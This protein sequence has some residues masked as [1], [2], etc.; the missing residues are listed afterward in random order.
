MEPGSPASLHPR[1]LAL[2]ISAAMFMGLLNSMVIGPAMPHMALSFHVQPVELSIGVTIYVLALTVLLPT[3]A[4]IADRF[5]PRR[6]FITAIAA[7]TVTSACVGLTQSL[8]QFV[9]ARGLQGVAGA[10]MVPVGI[11]VLLRLTDKKDLVSVMNISTAPALAA[12]VIGPPIGG[13]IADLLSWHWIFF[14]N[15]PLGL[16]VLWLAL[17]FI[18]KT[19]PREV[20]EPLAAFD[21]RGFLLTGF[22]MTGVIYGL[23]RVSAA[24]EDRWLALVLI[25]AGALLFVPAIRHALTHPRP[26]VPLG[27]LHIQ[28]FRVASITGG[29]LVKTPYLAMAFVLPLM[30]QIGLGLSASATGLLLLGWNGGELALK[31]VVVRILRHGGFRRILRWGATLTALS[32]TVWLFFTPTTPFWLLFLGLTLNG[33]CRSVLFTGIISLVFSEVPRHEMGAAV[34]LNNLGNAVMMALGVSFS[35]LVLHSSAWLR[36]AEHIGLMDF[37]VAVAIMVVMCLSALVSFS[38]LPHDTGAAIIGRRRPP[39]VE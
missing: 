33:M 21:T 3:A 26:V 30:L 19:G 39:P 10:F 32:M 9:A 36:G 37:R 24:G 12:P 29:G 31:V 5:G 38:R 11:M 35:A 28:T 6:V 22:A 16:A 23:T 2:I 8:W 7:F 25:V 14:I 27:P 15:V 34:V 1:R 20:H 18:P 4:W 17:R 13:F